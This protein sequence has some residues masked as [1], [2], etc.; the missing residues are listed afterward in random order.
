MK[1]VEFLTR[2]YGEFNYTPRSIV[3]PY[4]GQEYDKE[5]M[6]DTILSNS[7]WRP[8]PKKLY[9][10]ETFEIPEWM[11]P[12]EF[13][14]LE[15]EYYVKI[16]GTEELG[17]EVYFKITS[18]KNGVLRL[19]A[20]KLLKTKKFRSEFRKS[21]KEQLVQ[22]IENEHPKYDNPFS[23]KQKYKLCDSYTALEAKRLGIA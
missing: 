16:G 7:D 19:A 3:E 5:A 6:A 17:R 1:K 2:Q 15:W 4:L 12:K 23:D 22:W 11:N 20:M 13:S 18:I 8:H 9:A 10:V 14:Q 21:L